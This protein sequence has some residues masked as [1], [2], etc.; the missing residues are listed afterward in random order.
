MR[1]NNVV[2][3]IAAGEKPVGFTMRFPS[4]TI[5]EMMGLVGFDF[6][7]FDSEHGPFTTSDIE[8]LARAADAAGLTPMARVPNIHNSTILR[9]LDRGIMG[10]MGP[11][12]NTKEQAQALA[13]ACRYVPDG[14]RSF[15]SGRGSHF[16]QN[17]F[18]TG[19]M[20]H[21]NENVVV[22]AQLEDVAVL[23][24]LDGILSVE[25]IDFFTSGAQDI[26]QSLGLPGQ[27]EHPKVLE[28]E[29][30]VRDAVRAA[31]RQMAAD[32]MVGFTLDDM[33]F[34]IGVTALEAA[35]NQAG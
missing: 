8:E 11:H 35:K 15:G 28:F 6:V 26:A 22:I 7:M 12:I 1:T 10:I 17:T 32:V 24:D 34:E 31:G 13:D 9:F 23:D 18:R 27:G 29:K 30:T 3:K 14:H 25:G 21:F 20:K 2:T 4:A 16:G 19:Y 5:V 33:I